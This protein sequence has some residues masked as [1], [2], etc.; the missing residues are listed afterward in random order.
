MANPLQPIARLVLRAL[1]WYP[2][3]LLRQGYLR[4]VG[5][6]RSTRSREPQSKDG[7]PLPWITYPALRFLEPRLSSSM[8]VFE[9]GSGNSTL[10]WAER[11]GSVE[12]C[13]HDPEW[14]EKTRVR[15][16]ANARVIHRELGPGGSYTSAAAA[17]ERSFDIIVIDGRERLEC[18]KRCLPALKERGVIVWDNSEREE[19]REGLEFLSAHDF[20]QLTFEGLGPVNP[21]VWRTSILYRR[22]NCLGI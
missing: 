13:E 19:F 7:A 22:D 4:D 20:R 14:F 11:V 6:L 2:L 18:A 1:G 21:Y 10:W 9:Y 12:A 17:S 8:E 15:L 3:F 16:P 5:W